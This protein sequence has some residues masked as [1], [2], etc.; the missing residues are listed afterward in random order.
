MRRALVGLISLVVSFLSILVYQGEGIY[1]LL[2]GLFVA[3][4]AELFLYALLGLRIIRK[5]AKERLVAITAFKVLIIAPLSMMILFPPTSKVSATLFIAG[6]TIGF[7]VASI[8]WR[9]A[10]I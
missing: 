9:R 8:C 3:V 5:E 1:Q 4:G 7:F 6:L 10:K 2:A